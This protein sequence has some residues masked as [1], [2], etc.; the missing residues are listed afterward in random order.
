MRLSVQ[1]CWRPTERK[2]LE[3]RESDYGWVEGI[4]R[5][6]K[7]KL[8]L[9]HAGKYWS[10]NITELGHEDNHETRSELD[11]TEERG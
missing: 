10:K 3:R 2:G 1:M 5:I 4:W 7:L 6:V 9:G 11:R 8:L